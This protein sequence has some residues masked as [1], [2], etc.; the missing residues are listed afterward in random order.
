MDETVVKTGREVLHD[1][2]SADG[3]AQWPVLVASPS[4]FAPYLSYIEKTL[5]VLVGLLV[6]AV[7]LDYAGL[8]WFIVCLAFILLNLYWR[9]KAREKSIHLGLSEGWRFVSAE[10]TLYQLDNGKCIRELAV[11]D[12]HN[13]L[14]YQFQTRAGDRYLTLEYRRPY[15][16]PELTLLQFVHSRPE[17]IPEFRAAAQHLAD[18]MGISLEDK[19]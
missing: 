3:R 12:E 17:D 13:L 6:L 2:L 7:A 8:V 4:V 9:V 14:I 10:R 15:P 19:L 5:I 18:L 16:A 11:Q 1:L